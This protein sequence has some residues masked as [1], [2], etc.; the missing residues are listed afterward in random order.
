MLVIVVTNFTFLSNYFEDLFFTHPIYSVNFEAN[1]PC[2]F[3]MFLNFVFYLEPISSHFTSDSILNFS[4]IT[5]I[6]FFLNCFLLIEASILLSLSI[7]SMFESP[8]PAILFNF[9][10]W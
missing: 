7:H 4:V 3:F 1:F 8:H 9:I 10:G 5:K 6:L 2:C